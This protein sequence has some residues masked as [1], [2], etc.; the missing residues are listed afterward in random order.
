MLFRSLV[1]HLEQRRNLERRIAG[2]IFKEK[3]VVVK[4]KEYELSDVM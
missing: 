1:M 3:A 2:E 4:A